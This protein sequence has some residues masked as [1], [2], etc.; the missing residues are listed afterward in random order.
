MH[1]YTNGLKTAVLLAAM[2]GLIL[3][4]GAWIGGKSG[5]IVAFAI[6]IAMNGYSFFTSD[7]IALRSTRPLPS[8]RS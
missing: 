6:A 5:L 8:P 4:A 1:R 7:K 3:L 2:S